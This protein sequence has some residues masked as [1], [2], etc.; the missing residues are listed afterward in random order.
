MPSIRTSEKRPPDWKPEIG[1]SFIDPDPRER[2]R[3]VTIVKLGGGRIG[4]RAIY[5]SATGNEVGISVHRL[6]RWRGT[7]EPK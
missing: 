4:A 5:Y 3:V 7:W 2:G 6:R 1:Q